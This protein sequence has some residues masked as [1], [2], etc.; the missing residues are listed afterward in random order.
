MI[1]V[2]SSLIIIDLV[3]TA[4]CLGVTVILGTHFF[5]S[6]VLLC[7]ALCDFDGYSLL[8]LALIIMRRTTGIRIVSGHFCSFN[9]L[10]QRV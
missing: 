3:F 10:L 1:S 7:E 2:S 8:F 6:Q 4:V 5:L 9:I